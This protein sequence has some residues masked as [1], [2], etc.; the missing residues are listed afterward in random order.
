M[1]YLNYPK[2]SFEDILDSTILVVD[3]EKTN[4]NMLYSKIQNSINTGCYSRG[5]TSP[6][7][8]S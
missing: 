5:S 8:R 1:N 7:S 3:D 4:V 6:V 2:K